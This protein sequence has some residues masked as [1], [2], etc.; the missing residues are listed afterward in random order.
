M[1]L[2]L[3]RA[4]AIVTSVWLLAG[5]AVCGANEIAA[6]LNKHCS[7]CHDAET[8]EAGL[9]LTALEFDFADAETFSRWVQI[10][11]RIASGEMPPSTE[12]R[13]P[14][15]DVSQVTGRLKESLTEA[16]RAGLAESGRSG[17]RRMTRIEYEHTIRDLL[18]MPGIQV[19][20]LLPADGSAHG[21]DKHADALSLSHV[22][23]D[24]YL[25][26][27]DHV[28]DFAIA[29]QPE[30]PTCRTQ[31]VSLASQYYIRLLIA[32]NG[33]AVFLK[34]MQPDPD[35]LP[36]GEHQH[37]NRGA[38]ERLGMYETDSSVGVFRHEDASFRP[39]F[40][41]F[42]AIYPGR[43]R[44]KT[45]L[46]SYTWD[47]G[48]VLPARG[49]EAARLSV[50][51]LT[52]RGLGQ[53]H[54]S[55]V[56]G[57]FD[58]PS[59]KPQVHE[60][61]QWLNPGESIGFNVA[62]LAPV[63][64][65]HQY[66]R[67]L[68]SF[69][70]PG[71]ACDGMEIEG[72]IHDL[73]PPP[74][75]R[76]LFGDLP[77]VEFNPQH[78][79]I[80]YP[81]RTPPAQRIIA[82]SNR[83]DPW[84]GNW[85]VHSDTPLRD[86]R[87]LLSEFLPKAF[88][89]PVAQEVV[90]AYVAQVERRLQAGDCFE[91]AMRWAYRAA[92]CSPDFLYHIEPPGQ[93]DDY[94]LANRLSYFLWN[95]LPDARLAQ[96]AASGEIRRPEVL[97]AEIERMLQDAKSQRLIKD[98]LG[99]WLRLREIAA[100]DPD[101]KLYPEFSTYLQNSMVA[102]TEAYFRELIDQD[103]DATHLI[104]SD[105]AMINEKLAVHYGIE[106]VSGSQM[107]RVALPADCPRGGFLTQASILKITAN[108]TTTS[109]VP[110]GAFVIDRLLGTPPDPPPANVPAIEPDVRGATTIRQQL[111]RHRSDVSCAACH[112]K[113]D[114]A[115]FALEAFDVIGGYRQRYRSIGNGD[116][117]QR[118]SIDP[119]IH[120]GFRLGPPVD[121][122]GQL[123]DG[124]QFDGVAELQRLLTED[125]T[126]LLSNLARQLAVYAT[127]REILFSDRE[128]IAAIVS[129]TQA[130]GGGV[131]TLIKQLAESPLFQTR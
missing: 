110:R 83:A 18:D 9:D 15:A 19:R 14:A 7:T 69:T 33:G 90:E 21:F 34:D 59:L 123:A 50:M 60:L 130:S 52:G 85:T 45:S 79:H 94:G 129:Q 80:R 111:A 89:R 71:I 105:F 72:P 104:D 84:Q 86:A 66:K 88:R 121:S 48:Q 6:F 37:I 2:A 96:L 124:R 31:Q 56:I 26:S 42:A 24:K 103:L 27:A 22:H 53:D 65:Y 16:Q 119:F 5:P 39:W 127:G 44:V 131:R 20:D 92:L 76:A 61:V 32:N 41:G 126:P 102:E 43:Y 55:Y 68:M 54:P 99:Q 117:P 25:E 17:I 115:G 12:A 62:S 36:T 114:P 75:H 47:Q 49:T 77:L 98:F 28:L 67:N 4:A 29:T 91:L 23:L 38:H 109:P 51:Q 73:W 82:T 107:R 93:L 3:G 87:H 64:I 78:E 11:D 100:T 8:R 108:G 113:I 74:A 35:F 40:Q 30:P 81:E 95:S 70:G 58:A 101:G 97:R 46:W 63:H 118:G 122:S 125:A 13:P 112:A 106:G 120:L 1:K 10:H 128:Q 116:P 57:Y